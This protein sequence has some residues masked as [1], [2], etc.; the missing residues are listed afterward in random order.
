MGRK[1]EKPNASNPMVA[2]ESRNDE[3]SGFL[4][5]WSERKRGARGGQ[6]DEPLDAATPS[7]PQGEAVEAVNEQANRVLTDED[8]PPLESLDEDSDYSGFL[9]PG[10]SERLRRAALRKLFSSPKLNVVDG[11][12]DYA[13]DY[14]SFEALGDIVTADMR[15]DQEREAER[16]KQ[17]LEEQTREAVEDTEVAAAQAEEKAEEEAAASSDEPA[18]AESNAGDT[19][20]ARADSNPPDADHDATPDEDNTRTG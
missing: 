6:E 7:V 9:S 4:R 11:L 5:R 10:V 8:M 17:A 1:L 13:E 15:F 18:G 20:I 16:A 19:R 14:R 3:G 2:G 12:D